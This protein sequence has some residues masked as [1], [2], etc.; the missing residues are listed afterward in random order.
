MEMT[1]IS[2]RLPSEEFSAEAVKP[3]GFADGEVQALQ[4]LKN[5]QVR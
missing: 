1:A 2:R 3:G 5:M 4:A